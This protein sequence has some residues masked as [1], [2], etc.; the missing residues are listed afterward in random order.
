[1]EGVRVPDDGHIASLWVRPAD[2]AASVARCIVGLNVWFPPRRV[3]HCAALTV[4]VYQAVIRLLPACAGGA[5][6]M[7]ELIGF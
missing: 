5:P 2:R 6:Q 3:K 7:I 1:V 4:K